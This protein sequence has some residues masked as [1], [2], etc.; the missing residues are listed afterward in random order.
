MDHSF[1]GA[2]KES[3]DE[4]SAHYSYWVRGRTQLGIALSS[5]YHKLRM[6]ET[7]CVLAS[8]EAI[9]EALTAGPIAQW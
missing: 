6:V 5:K 3:R 4:I 9:G 7:S 2:R 8:I 1:G